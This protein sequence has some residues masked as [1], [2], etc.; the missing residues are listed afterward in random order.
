MNL[1]SPVRGLTGVLAL[2]SSAGSSPCSG[3]TVGSP[4]SVEVMMIAL[5]RY[6][7]PPAKP[8]TARRARRCPSR[9]TCALISA[10]VGMSSAVYDLGMAGGGFGDM[11]G[12]PEE[13]QRRLAE[14]AEQMQGSQR[15]A[16]ADNAIKLAVDMTVAAVNRINLQGGAEAQ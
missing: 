16:W 2:P 11:F 14:F 10:A 1:T 5:S 7:K 8:G 13:L 12:D 4:L 9:A 3:P 6:R 15:L